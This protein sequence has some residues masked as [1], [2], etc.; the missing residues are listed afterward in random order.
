MKKS[1]ILGI[2]GV[3]LFTGCC[4]RL[5]LI[6]CNSG[7]CTATPQQKQV[8]VSTPINQPKPLIRQVSY[9]NKTCYIKNGYNQSCVLKLEAK[10]VGVPP[11]EGTCSSAQAIAMARR[12]AILDAYKALA[13]KLYGVKINGRDTVKNMILQNSSIRAYVDG[14]IRG[15]NIESEEYKNGIYSVV[16]SIKV[17]ANEWNKYLSRSGLI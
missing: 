10:G 9:K 6:D 14:V 16:M 5:A 15:A 8:N 4:K 13:E 17:D 1:L 3:L 11:C 12:A 2:G 7:S